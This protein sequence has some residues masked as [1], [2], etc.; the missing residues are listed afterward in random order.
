MML[1]ASGQGLGIKQRQRKTVIV[2]ML[3]V[4]RIL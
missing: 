3:H 2:S 4:A 1:L